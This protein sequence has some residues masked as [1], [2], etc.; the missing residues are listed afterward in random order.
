MNTDIVDATQ[1]SYV[2]DPIYDVLHF[3]SFVKV[4]YPDGSTQ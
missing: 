2:V 1:I 3:C 4:L